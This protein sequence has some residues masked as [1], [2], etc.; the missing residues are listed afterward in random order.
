MIVIVDS[1]Y[2]TIYMDRQIDSFEAYEIDKTIL[3]ED[4]LDKVS[5]RFLELMFKYDYLKEK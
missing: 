5:N 3:R 4:L 1:K 2:Q